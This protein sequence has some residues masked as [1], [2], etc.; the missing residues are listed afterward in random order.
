M[1]DA[2]LSSLP[3][4]LQ[5]AASL[6]GADTADGSMLAA[7]RSVFAPGDAGGFRVYLD[8]ACGMPADWRQH[9]R[10]SSCNTTSIPS[11]SPVNDFKYAAESFLPNLLAASPFVTSDWRRANASLVV[12]YAHVYGGP[13]L[14]PERCR[15]ALAQRSEAWRATGG[16]RH[17]FVLTGDFG[18]CDHTG[19]ML[20]PA[21]LRH[22]IIATHGELDGHHWHWGTGP[23]F[24]C[25]VPQK[26]ISIPPSNWHKRPALMDDQIS[27]ASAA[28]ATT[29]ATVP[30]YPQANRG[31]KSTAREL[32]AFFA[33][34]GEFR[35]GKRQGRQLMLRYWGHDA[36]PS[37]RAVT[38]LPREQM[39]ANMTRAK[40]C[41]IFGGNS[42]W[43]TRLV[44]AMVCGC[45]PVF[46]SAWLPPFSRLLDWDRFSVR[47]P[48]LNLVPELKTFLE[49]Q[50]YEMLAANVPKAL[51]AIWYRVEGGY[52]GDDLL[53]F[54]L[55]EMHLALRA[56]AKRPLAELA[57][58]VVG[59]PLHLSHF[60][61]DVLAN[62]SS[63][64]AQQLPPRI[65]ALVARA[66][67]AFSA[68]YRGG[69]TIVSNR[70]KQLREQVFRCVPMMQNGHSYRLSD[71]YT[72]RDGEPG[73]G[74]ERLSLLT[75][76]ECRDVPKGR[77]EAAHRLDDPY[78]P[79][80][81]PTNYSLVR[82]NRDYFMH[83][84]P[85]AETIR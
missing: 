73:V 69:V 76:F 17:F 35:L 27:G 53:G 2:T 7:A 66:P 14:G 40:Y 10:L 62:R 60:D 65:A 29:P 55:V 71:P 44:E 6:F 13:V 51:G 12:L 75:G 38:R 11:V 52:Q 42:P 18:V 79:T 45:V 20:T 1:D 61:D 57:D 19:H 33:G 59:M 50:P 47:V 72:F 68:A 48:S 81:V 28:T 84:K 63:A 23:S 36:D 64:L 56:A 24:P 8:D 82:G 85:R 58:E 41:P 3:P 9:L 54:L 74:D 16:A 46:F 4:A 31:Q 32:L 15:R 26:D 80:Q 21:L 39:M 5:H 83:R 22:H 78:S 67:K 30:S 70:T 77:T 25:F 34:A 49:R 37:I 43:S